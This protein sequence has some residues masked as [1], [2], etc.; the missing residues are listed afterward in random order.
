[1]DTEQTGTPPSAAPAAK[2]P[3]GL[4]VAFI[5]VTAVLLISALLLNVTVQRMKLS[6]RKEP[7]ALRASLKKIDA[8]MGPWVQVTLDERLSHEMEDALAATEYVF[9]DYVDSRK[10]P[11]EVLAQ[12]R[13]KKLDE[14][15]RLLDEVRLRSPDAVIHM[16][17]AFYTGMVD[18]VAHIPDRC[19]IADGFEPSAYE[20]RRW[21]CFVE[22]DADARAASRFIYFEDQVSERKAL[23]RF[24]SYTFH[25]N[26]RYTN[27]PEDVRLTLQDLRQKYGYY[28]KIELMWVPAP[29]AALG[30]SNAEQFTPDA[31][32]VMSDFL[33]HA[34]PAVE[35]VLP[36][37]EK[38]QS[39]Q[40]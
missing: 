2:K 4:D 23:P 39:E 30:T 3:R 22:R 8:N 32:R 35:K 7:V 21:P 24:V 17:V 10:V 1:M 40:K 16:Q 12:F 28:T 36:D 13:G 14:Q 27:S 25:V 38:L 29:R 5:I 6:F 31:D 26:G 34:L 37:W 33:L 20:I 19:Y 11:A 18:T 9:R 15:R